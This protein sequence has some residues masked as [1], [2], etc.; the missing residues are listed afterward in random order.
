MNSANEAPFRPLTIHRL[1]D[2]ARYQKPYYLKTN[3]VDAYASGLEVMTDLNFVPAAAIGLDADLAHASQ[4]MIARGVRL[5][6]VVDS[7]HYV[8]G[9]LTARDVM[10]DRCTQIAEQL[11][12]EQ[13]EVAVRDI[14]TPVSSIQV[15]ELVDVVH[16]RVG[17]IIE[18]LRHSS[19][20]HAIV[21]DREPP[22]DKLIIRGIFSASQIAR[23]LGVTQVE[24]D[25]EHTFEQ[26]D[27]AI[28][29][30]TRAT[31]V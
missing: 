6:L 1:N 10:G 4:M 15:L 13:N 24:A 3:R 23:Q 19:R 27:T 5:L 26:I 9:L 11:N 30:S 20:Q 14:M 2:P 17:D 31:P 8:L 21:I 22:D 29:V 7:D 28:R 18:T 12:I 16:A 25:L